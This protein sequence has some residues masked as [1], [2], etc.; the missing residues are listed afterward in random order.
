VCRDKL[1][2]FAQCTNHTN[3]E[4]KENSKSIHNIKRDPNMWNLF[5]DGSKYLEGAGIGCI[6]KY[7]NG[8]KVMITCRMEFQCT[9]NIVEYETLLQGLRKTIDL[10]AKKIKVFG[11]SEIVIR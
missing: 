1:K 9:N 10:E 8:K 7:P 6:L 4:T 5:F 3:I 11:D 2:V